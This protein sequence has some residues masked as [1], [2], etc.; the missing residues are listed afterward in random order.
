MT[1][2]TPPQP[3]TNGNPI[4]KILG[5]VNE[6]EK[7]TL[8]YSRKR[9]LWT[10]LLGAVVAL[11][12]AISL[13]LAVNNAQHINKNTENLATAAH[14]SA[15]RANTKGN[16]IYLFLR[17]QRGLPGVPGADG[18]DGS[19]GQPGSNPALLPPG[20]AGPQ[21]PKGDTGPAG[22]AGQ[23][24]AQGAVGAVGQ[25]GQQGAQGNTGETGAQGDQG[26][27]GETGEQGK[28][29]QAGEAGEKGAK[30]DTGATG[31]T[32]AQGIPGPAGPPGPQ[33]DPGPAGPIGPAGVASTQVVST[34]SIDNPGN[35]KSVT[36][37]CP[38]G[39]TI[40][41]GGFTFTPS[42]TQIEL[43]AS[44]PDGNGW[45]ID[46]AE[47]GLSAA[48]SWHITAFAVCSG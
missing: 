43:Q 9:F 7:R 31:E 35:S 46:A 22:S 4:E 34:D 8:G 48:V 19:P 11:L 12:T 24:G 29:G 27:T 44:L 2:E 17:G 39:T 21:G 41:S 15:G 47:D 20:P 18:K 30:G 3:A 14:D 28:Q 5:E 33:G 37:A 36:A 1:V 32:G 26:A 45:R 38:T 10:W 13:L 23:Q 42:V 6:Q 40:V 16:D 25:T